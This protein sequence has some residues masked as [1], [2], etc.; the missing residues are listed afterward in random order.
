MHISHLAGSISYIQ[1]FLAFILI[2]PCSIAYFISSHKRKFCSDLQ[3]GILNLLLVAAVLINLL[4]VVIAYIY[5]PSI[6]AIILN[7]ASIIAYGTTL[8]INL[9]KSIR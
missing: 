1:V 4:L 3:E 7:S 9:K 8:I 5:T 6:I 2:L